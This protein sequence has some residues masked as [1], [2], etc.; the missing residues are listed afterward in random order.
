MGEWKGSL[1]LFLVT[2]P[3]VSVTLGLRGSSQEL[4]S[5]WLY[6]HPFLIYHPQVHI[7]LTESTDYL[8]SHILVQPHSKHEMAL[9]KTSGLNWVCPFLSAIC[10]GYRIHSS[11]LQEPAVASWE[12][13]PFIVHHEAYHNRNCKHTSKGMLSSSQP[14]RA[15]PGDDIIPA[16]TP[17]CPT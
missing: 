6:C 12:N 14:N 1:L 5:S 8:L 2:V 15:R 7:Q 13:F 16:T 10:P 11:I 9:A 4:F 3:W 17:P